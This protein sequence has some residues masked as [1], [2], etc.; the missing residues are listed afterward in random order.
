MKKD[1]LNISR[2]TEELEKQNCDAYI[3]YASAEDCDMRYLSRFLASDPYLYFCTKNGQESLIVASMEVLRAEKEAR[4]PAIS[5][6]AAGYMDFLEDGCSADEAAARMLKKCCSTGDSARFL[7]PYTM[8]AG[9]ARA[10]FGHA[11]VVIDAGAVSAMRAV[12]SPE[13]IDAIREV[14]R[15]NEK[16]V[17]CAIEAVRKAE[18]A[19]NDALLFEGEALTS[20]KIRRILHD[21]FYDAGL[22]DRDT[23]ISCGPDTALPHAKGTGQLFAHMPIVMDVF[24]R[25]SSGYFADMTRTVSKGK[26][27]DAIC[28]MYQTVHDAKELAASMIRPGVSG[29]DVHNAVSAYFKDHGYETAGTSGFIHGLGHG[30]GLAIH[31]SPS[32]SPRGEILAEGN[33]VTIEPGLYY[34]GTGGVRL[35]D[36]GAV[37][38]DGFDRFTIFEEELIIA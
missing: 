27:D 3:A 24:P 19:E 9:F 8:P 16:G 12:K 21:V 7:V 14:Q 37:T 13:E 33:V 17:H 38:S 6:T 32:L 31:E 29:A 35:E 2:L 34:P 28:A 10:L 18:I 15:E 23:I 36:M 1:K 25:G 20:E 22:E 11:E 30:V 26:P 5:R 4:C